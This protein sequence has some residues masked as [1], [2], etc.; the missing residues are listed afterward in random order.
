MSGLMKL[1]QF[2]VIPNTARTRSVFD[3]LNLS[4]VPV[5]WMLAGAWRTLAVAHTRFEEFAGVMLSIQFGMLW[6]VM[7]AVLSRRGRRA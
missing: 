3:W 4:V 5:V 7:Y 6:A 2:D 1:L